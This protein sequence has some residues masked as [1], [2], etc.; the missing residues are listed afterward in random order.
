MGKKNHHNLL[1]NSI[2]NSTLEEQGNLDGA[3]EFNNL[4]S[5]NQQY[6]QCITSEYELSRQRFT[7]IAHA[8]ATKLQQLARDKKFDRGTK[9]PVSPLLYNTLNNP[10]VCK[11]ATIAQELEDGKSTVTDFDRLYGRP[12]SH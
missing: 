7:L 12:G 5:E 8:E 6:E 4:V 1:K 2:E 11:F 10:M 9:R 3:A